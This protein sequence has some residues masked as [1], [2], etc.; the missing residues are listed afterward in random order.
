MGA[1]EGDAEGRLVGFDDGC[2]L[3]AVEGDDEGTKEGVVVGFDEGVALGE[4][5]G[6]TTIEG[7]VDGKIETLGAG[8]CVV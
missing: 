2:A 3:G 6:C 5:L 1:N 8:D 7:C 4:S